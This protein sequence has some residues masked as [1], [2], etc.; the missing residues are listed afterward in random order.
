MGVGLPVAIGPVD[1]D[2]VGTSDTEWSSDI[3]MPSSPGRPGSI[4]EGPDL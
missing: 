2:R 3:L 4:Q 1:R